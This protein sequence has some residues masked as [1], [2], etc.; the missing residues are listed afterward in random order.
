MS[1]IVFVHFSGSGS[2]TDL[3]YLHAAIIQA[4]YSSPDSRVV[5]IGDVDLPSYDWL[6][7]E[8]IS[9]YFTGAELFFR[10][11]KFAHQTS[12]YWYILAV[13]GRLFVL[14]E[15][16]QKKSIE[17]CVYLESDVL[18]YCPYDV[19]INSLDGLGLGYLYEKK[20]NHGIFGVVG[21]TDLGLFEELIE[22]FK[23][24]MASLGPNDTEMRLLSSFYVGNKNRVCN[25]CEFSKE[26]HFDFLITSSEEEYVMESHTRYL[27][28]YKKIQKIDGSFYIDRNGSLQRLLSLHL[29]AQF[30]SDITKYISFSP[31][32]LTGRENSPFW[33]V[34]EELMR[35]STVLGLESS[36]SDVENYL[37][38]EPESY[39]GY[40]EL[41]KIKKRMGALEEGLS[42]IL[43]S[44]EKNPRA[45][46]LKSFAIADFLLPLKK[47][48][49]AISFCD[50]LI[51]E[52]KNSFLGHFYKSYVYYLTG[53]IEFAHDWVSAVIVKH[54]Q[55]A[56][57]WKLW[58]QICSKMKDI[59]LEEKLRN[60]DFARE[61]FPYDQG[62]I[63]ERN[64]FIE[65]SK[66]N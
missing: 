66:P 15:Y 12:P 32:A 30:K 40:Y 63:D 33:S 47:Y 8:E 59:T 57:G 44:I 7:K 27:R 11:F 54:P 35:E 61:R 56:R 22:Y 24:N 10:E 16:M 62:I 1:I 55:Q 42:L 9:E 60:F 13:Y 3:E 6:I 4:H 65:N 2:L 49:E 53:K 51:S 31:S 39:R 50:E 17:E 14:Y 29:Q 41:S 46:Y 19:I 58:A 28:S 21:I 45:L 38:A 64:R 20:C 43:K 5:L 36:F 52:N 18:I 23:M 26:G 34:E 48:D 25:L 37:K